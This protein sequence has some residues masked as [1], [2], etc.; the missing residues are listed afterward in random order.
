MFRS[1]IFHSHIKLADAEG[2][3]LPYLGRMSSIFTALW[4]LECPSLLAGIAGRIS[5]LL[6]PL[7]D[8]GS[9]LVVCSTYQVGNQH[10]VTQLCMEYPK[11]YWWTASNSTCSRASKTCVWPPRPAHVFSRADR[12][13]LRGMQ[14]LPRVVNKWLVNPH[15]NNTLYIYIYNSY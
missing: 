9:C 10:I 5:C 1:A 15:Q 7:E 11:L 6:L 12:Q 3:L 14:H 8:V 4:D 13:G 2:R